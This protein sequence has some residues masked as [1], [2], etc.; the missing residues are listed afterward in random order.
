MS[1]Q[2]LTQ[3]RALQL[4]PQDGNGNDT[5]RIRAFNTQWSLCFDTHPVAIK[6]APN[7]V[8]SHQWLEAKITV[9]QPPDGNRGTERDKDVSLCGTQSHFYLL[10]I[11]AD[12]YHK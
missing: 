4:C 10:P 3:E 8:Q 11:G 1:S 2:Y 6:L 9:V 7:G 5:K 12:A